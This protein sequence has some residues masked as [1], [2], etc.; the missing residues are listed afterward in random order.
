MLMLSQSYPRNR[1]FSLVEMLVAA[2]LLVLLVLL[3][4]QIVNSASSVAAEARKRLDAD[5]QARMVLDR[6]AQ[7][8]GRMN[9]GSEVDRFFAGEAGND[10]MIFVSE[11]PGYFSGASAE[12]QSGLSLIGYR[13]NSDHALQRL[14]KGLAWSGGGAN[15]EITFLTYHPAAQSGSYQPLAG[16]T[17]AGNPVCLPD[18]ADAD[19]QTIS[20]AVFR[21]EFCY[22]LKDGTFSTK[23][24]AEVGGLRNALSANTAPTVSE[25]SNEGYSAGS[26]WYDAASRRAY[27]CVDASPNAAVWRALGWKD[28]HAVVVAVAALDGASRKLAP[29]LQAAAAALPD[30]AEADLQSG[31]ARLMEESWNGVLRDG[32]FAQRSGMPAAAANAVRVYQRYFYLNAP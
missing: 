27:V 20:D 12:N 18:A 30:V 15:N 19:F 16:S 6:I 29:S 1:A 10:R 9:R 8:F 5:S 28:V 32:S 22:L 4:A 14:A 13:F 7:D 23:P 31:A 24:V 3:V 17:I 26:R 2:A 25:G 11:T 21:L